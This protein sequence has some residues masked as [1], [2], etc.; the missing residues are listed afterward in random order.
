MWELLFFPTR[1]LGGQCNGSFVCIQEKLINQLYANAVL[2]QHSL[3]FLTGIIEFS[4]KDSLQS[5][6][7]CA[8]KVKLF[9]NW[10][11]WLLA[12]VFVHFFSIYDNIP[13]VTTVF[14]G[15]SYLKAQGLSQYFKLP[16]WVSMPW[17]CM[18]SVSLELLW[19]KSRREWKSSFQEHHVQHNLPFQ[20]IYLLGLP[21]DR[22]S[23]AAATTCHWLGGTN[24]HC[25][26]LWPWGIYDLSLPLTSGKIRFVKNPCPLSVA[27][28]LFT[29]FLITGQLVSSYLPV[30]I[31][32]VCWPPICHYVRFYGSIYTN[33]NIKHYLY[34]HTVFHCIYM[35][36]MTIRTCL[37]LRG[38]FLLPLLL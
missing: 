6:W 1:C 23:G 17:P 22:Y 14:F 11:D 7:T 20:I 24:L 18:P 9:L 2:P 33:D 3:A 37:N 25:L 31:L 28:N 30:H 19:D 32:T 27:I 38:D 21:L 26:C 29:I 13:I 34:I 10:S 5:F 35:V 36:V 12:P 15:I 8:I 16:T 4:H